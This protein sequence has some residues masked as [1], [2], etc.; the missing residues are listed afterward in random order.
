VRDRGSERKDVLWF[1]RRLF[2]KEIQEPFLG[3]R[4]TGLHALQLLQHR[5][6]LGELPVGGE[7]FDEPDEDLRRPVLLALRYQG[8]AELEPD[9]EVGGVVLKALFQEPDRLVVVLL[10]EKVSSEY[11]SMKKES[12]RANPPPRRA[13]R[14][15]RIPSAN[16]FL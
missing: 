2:V 12:T 4:L 5:D 14:A 6:G 13:A 1:V 15:G 3:V 10:R 7:L 11:G 8:V 9:P 16:A